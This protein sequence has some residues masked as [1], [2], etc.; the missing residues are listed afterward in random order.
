VMQTLDK[1]GAGFSLASYGMDIRGAGNLLGDEQSGHVKEVGIELYQDMLRQAVEMAKQAADP[2]RNISAGTGTGD[3][4]ENWSPQITLGTSVLIPESYVPDLT[5]RL[6]LYRRIANLADAEAVS[7]LV[8]ELKDR[9]GPVPA[10]VINLVEVVELKQLCRQLNI[11][12]I[13]AGGKGFALSFR[14]NEFEKPEALVGW[15]AGKAGQVLLKADQR[16]I[17]KSELGK[18]GTRA[19][20]AKRM[21]SELAAL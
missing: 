18:I 2:E 11:A 21:L 17:I 10:E 6:S 1:L 7:G 16:L 5:V 15:I 3:E 20:I 19:R 14:N 9:F 4:D 8:A 12:K 13:D